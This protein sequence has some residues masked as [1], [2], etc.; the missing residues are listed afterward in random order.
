MR[1]I[2]FTIFLIVSGIIGCA[3]SQ[4]ITLSQ[5]SKIE[6]KHN[7]WIYVEKAGMFSKFEAGNMYYCVFDSTED[8]TCYKVKVKDNFLQE[9]K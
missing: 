7:I 2:L 9:E 6:G 1:K 3:H 8:P 5:N 4:P